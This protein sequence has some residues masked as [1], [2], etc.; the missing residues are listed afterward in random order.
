MRPVKEMEMIEI[1]REID[2]LLCEERNESEQAR[3]I[4]L[5]VVKDKFLENLREGLHK[6]WMG[7]GVVVFDNSIVEFREPL[8]FQPP[9]G[10]NLDD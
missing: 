2:N 6:V 8:L 5:T 3:L 10:E 7:D 9:I 4:E 1:Y